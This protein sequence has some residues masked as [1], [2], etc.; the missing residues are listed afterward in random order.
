MV[1]E[2]G[3]FLMKETIFLPLADGPIIANIDSAT[4]KQALYDAGMEPGVLEVRQDRTV[5]AG[6]C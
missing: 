1:Q 2:Y 5:L 6:M 4:L 3:T